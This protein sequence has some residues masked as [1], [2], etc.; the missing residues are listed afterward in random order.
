MAGCL[1][2]GLQELEGELRTETGPV[3]IEIRLV[4]PTGTNGI[5][6]SS[7]SCNWSD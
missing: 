4:E 2:M 3:T 5:S 7:S 1:G 6:H